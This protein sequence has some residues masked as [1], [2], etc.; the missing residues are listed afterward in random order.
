VSDPIKAYER[1]LLEL[2]ARHRGTVRGGARCATLM[3]A[4]LAVMDYWASSDDGSYVTEEQFA[5]FA[6][7]TYQRMRAAAA[8]LG[9]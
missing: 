6:R 1:D 4:A 9:N 8:R 5:E 7:R 2:D 3:I